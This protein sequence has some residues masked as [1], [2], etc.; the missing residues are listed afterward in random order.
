MSCSTSNSPIDITLSKISGKCELK[1]DYNFS[2]NNSSCVATNRGNYISLSYDNSNTPAVTY[3][4]IIYNVQ[5][6][7][8][9]I[10]SLHSYGGSKS[11]GEFIIV[12][13]STTGSKP[14]LVCIPI[15]INNSTSVSALFFT[16]LIDTI[17]NNAPSNGETTTI[18]ISNY[19]L[20]SFV[21]RKPFFSYSA[22]E[23]YQPCNT[24]VDFIVYNPQ[25]ATL[26]IT[27]SSFTK[28]KKIIEAQ[29]YNV[30]SGTPLYYNE[31]GPGTSGTDQ[32]YIDC[33][34]VGQSEETQVIVK[35]GYKDLAG[36]FIVKFISGIILF[37]LILYLLSFGLRMIQPLNI[38]KQK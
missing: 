36:N 9:Y 20:N 21:P 1:C 4:S 12:H 16:T 7:R 25:N 33:Q 17:S 27:K 11:D 32:I 24:N 2:Y 8:I 13:S 38:T 31:K 26:D 28:L 15:N 35:N 14:L 23:P 37:L 6:I 10:P 34:P 5:E 19:N 18:Q 29:T 3:N 22:K 30:K